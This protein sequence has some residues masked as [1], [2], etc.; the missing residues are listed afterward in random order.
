MPTASQA[1]VT[2]RLTH[3]GQIEHYGLSAAKM[4]AAGIEPASDG[5]GMCKLMALREAADG[6]S[7][8]RHH[9]LLA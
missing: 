2:R 8:Q 5:C 6:T 4:E 3:L 7:E 1:A 9:L